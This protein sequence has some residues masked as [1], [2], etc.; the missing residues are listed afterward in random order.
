MCVNFS[1]SV[2]FAKYECMVII[3]MLFERLIDMYTRASSDEMEKKILVS[4][5][6]EGRKL[7]C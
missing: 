5:V 1:L 6:T 7:S 4:F 3:V 2:A